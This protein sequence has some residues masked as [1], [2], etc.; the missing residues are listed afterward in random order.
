MDPAVKILSDCVTLFQIFGYQYFSLKSIFVKQ[1]F[2]GASPWNAIYFALSLTVISCLGI[3]NAWLSSKDSFQSELTA[4]TALSVIIQQLFQVGLILIYCVSSVQSFTSTSRMKKFFTNS[5]EISEIYRRSFHL[6]DHSRIRS[7]V[8][9]LFAAVSVFIVFMNIL[10]HFVEGENPVTKTVLSII[11]LVYHAAGIIKIVFLFKLVSFHLSFLNKS[12]DSM[13]TK[14][15]DLN[16]FTKSMRSNNLQIVCFKIKNLRKIYNIVLENSE[17]INSSCG[18]TLLT[19]FS[20]MIVAVS[21]F[22]YKFFLGFVGR[23]PEYQVSGEES[24]SYQH[25]I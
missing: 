22:C 4:K 11:L 24:E 23:V 19:I 10:L 12:L 25:F 21:A 5:I 17:I 20:M 7:K 9:G 8:F 18:L 1:N 15:L 16:L 14:T 13:T 2:K 3:L 6:M